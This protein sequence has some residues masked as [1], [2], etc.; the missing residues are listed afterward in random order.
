M[1]KCS[2]LDSE[3]KDYFC[4]KSIHTFPRNIHT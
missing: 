3:T 1:T 4:P 2:E